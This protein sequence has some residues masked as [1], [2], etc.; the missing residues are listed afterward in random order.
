MIAQYTADDQRSWDQLLPEISLAV[1]SS[2]SDSTGFSPAYLVQG[3]EPRL[4]GAWYDKV[5]PSSSTTPQPPDDRAKGL[6][7]AYAIARENNERASQEQ[8]RYY[9]LRRR[10]WRPLVGS[11]V[12]VRT[13]HLSKASEGFNAKL[14]PKYTGPYKVVK[15]LSHN[16]VLLQLRGSRKRRTASLPDLKEY[17]TGEADDEEDTADN[18]A[19]PYTEAFASEPP[20]VD[21]EDSQALGD[22]QEILGQESNQ[23]AQVT[24]QRTQPKKAT[25]RRVHSE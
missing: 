1:N 2:I 12:L 19:E 17:R 11:W 8:Q 16:V 18:E 5:T 20:N 13:L 6:Q 23:D 15:F 24:E 4:P 10:A 25:H 9:N 14:A 3:R 21:P 7:E 22:Q